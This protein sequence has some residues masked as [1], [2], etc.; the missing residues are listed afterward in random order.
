MTSAGYFLGIVDALHNLN[1]GVVLSTKYPLKHIKLKKNKQ[2]N[3]L[4]TYPIAAP[5]PKKTK[6]LQR[7]STKR[8]LANVR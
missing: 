6:K 7:L 8:L 4:L 2:T 1:T 5:P 3:N